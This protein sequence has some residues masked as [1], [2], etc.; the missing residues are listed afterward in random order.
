MKKILAE[1]RKYLEERRWDNLK[2]GDVA[3]SISIESG[4]LLEIFQWSNPTLE[5][6][7][8]DKEKME[9]L[10]KELADILIYALDIAVL[11][12]I[13]PEEI[14]MEKLEHIKKKYPAEL[15]KKRKNDESEAN[16][17]YW[18]IKKKYRK[19]A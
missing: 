5:E 1:I 10:R 6:V 11:L 2:P 14:I 16:D 4:E 12:N 19:L 7:R 15:M 18:K 9:H 8:K 17:E 3:K 13:D